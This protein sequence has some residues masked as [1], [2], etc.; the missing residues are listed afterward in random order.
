MVVPLNALGVQSLPANGETEAWGNMGLVCDAAF[1]TLSGFGSI[2]LTSEGFHS[3]L[4]GRVTEWLIVTPSLSI[5]SAC[6]FRMFLHTD[7]HLVLFILKVVMW[8]WYILVFP[9]S[10]YFE[11]PDINRYFIFPVY[12]IIE[13][14]PLWRVCIP[15]N[16]VKSDIPRKVGMAFKSQVPR[17]RGH[18]ATH[19]ES[20]R[21]NPQ[22]PNWGEEAV[23]SVHWVSPCLTRFCFP[24]TLQVFSLSLKIVF[25]K[26]LNK[27]KHHSSYG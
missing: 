16:C 7:F 14:T 18:L 22:T 2:S 5:T 13:R 27:C 20:A 11:S 17:R 26:Y 19:G 1:P 3:S 8:P 12:L 25:G 23:G 21:E 10:L 15:S 24:K 6:D 9:F 4:H